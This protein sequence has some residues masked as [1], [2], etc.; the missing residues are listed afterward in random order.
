MATVCYLTKLLEL[1]KPCK[2]PM[3]YDPEHPNADT[4]DTRPYDPESP[5]PPNTPRDRKDLMAY[6]PEDP[7]CDMDLE[8][9]PDYDPESPPVVPRDSHMYYVHY[10]PTSPAYSPTSPD[11]GLKELAS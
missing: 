2:D 1:A 6:D 11:Y 9:G 5:T 3:E 10:W 8:D 7:S 4:L